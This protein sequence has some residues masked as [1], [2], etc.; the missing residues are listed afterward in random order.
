MAKATS[1][2][3][4]MNT[5]GAPDGMNLALPPDEIPET[6]DRYLQD[7]FVDKPGLRRRRGKVQNASGFATLTRQAWGILSTVDPMGTP[8]YAVLNG[9]GASCH[10][11]FLSAPAPTS[12]TAELSWPGVYSPTTARVATSA[13]A[14]GGIVISTTDD[15]ISPNYPVIALWNGGNL[16]NYAAGTITCGA[17]GSGVIGVGTSWL[18]NLSPGMYLY[19]TAGQYI[20]TVLN[21][22]N[23]TNLSLVDSCVVSVSGGGYVASSV[24]LVAPR[25]TK[26]TLTCSSAH[27][28]AHGGDT[29]WQSQ[30]Q[31]GPTYQIFLRRNEAPIGII[32]VVQSDFAVTLTANAAQDAADA[33]YYVVNNQAPV[34][35]SGWTPPPVGPP[36]FLTAYYAGLQWYANQPNFAAYHPHPS[37][38]SFSDPLDPEGLDTTQDGDWFDVYSDSQTTQPIKA[39]V[40]TNAC[41]LILKEREVWGVFG[42]SPENFTAKLIGSDGCLDGPTVQA[43][44]GGAIWAG[45]DGIY[46]FDGSRIQNLTQNTLGKYFRDMVK[47]FDYTGSNVAKSMIARNHYFL[48]LPSMTGQYSLNKG[49]TVTTPTRGTLVI[50]LATNALTFLTNVDIMGATQTPNSAAP[51]ALYLV[52]DGSIGHICSADDLFDTPGTDAITCTGNAAG[53]DFF[54]ETKAHDAGDGVTPKR[55]RWLEANALVTGAALKVDAVKGLSSVDSALSDTIPIGTIFG[56][57]QRIDVNWDSQFMAFRFWQSSSGV[58]DAQIGPLQI[59]LKYQRTA[60]PL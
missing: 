39:I 12:I 35:L 37:R 48:Y 55:W 42:T 11:S 56:V 23:N 8:K 43:F 45:H 53:P 36:G 47:G 15:Y 34:I 17:G 16:A 57:G 31:G 51:T 33:P 29:K 10:I 18:T 20:G 13:F 22:Q 49:G 59:A 6:Q 28:H 38:V 24:R 21:I 26:G 54:V 19:T 4:F 46:F 1:T 25:V 30:L 50:N 52:N 5:R 27:P 14:N 32:S 40:S 58:T 7:V 44:A 60:R 2:L 9:T 41:L 3:S